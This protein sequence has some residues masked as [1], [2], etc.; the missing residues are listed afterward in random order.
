[1]V[2]PTC[3]NNHYPERRRCLR[4]PYT[5]PVRYS[6]ASLN[7]SGLV[8]DISS[9]GMFME[10]RVLPDVGDQIRIAFMLRNSRH[11]MDIDGEIARKVQSGVGVKFLWP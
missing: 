6:S 4:T 7:G 1:M 3:E 5:T 8:K 10:T 9:Y 2:Y 11:P